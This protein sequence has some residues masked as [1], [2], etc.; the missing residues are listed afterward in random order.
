M[1]DPERPASIESEKAVLGAILLNRDAIAS[2][3][4]TLKPGHFDYERHNQI[5]AAMLTLFQQHIPPD[6]RTVSEELR[7][8]GLLEQVGGVEYLSDLTHGVP[9]SYHIGFYA[10]DML[11]SATRRQLLTAVGKIAALA[12]NEQEDVSVLMEQAHALLDGAGIS[13]YDP[14]YRPFTADELDMEQL[15]E[16]IWVIPGLLPA[17]LTLLIGKPKMRKSW[18]ALATGIAVASG[19][20]ALGAIPVE[21]GDVLYLALE[22]SKNRLQ[23]RQ[24]KILS[25]GSAPHRLSYMTV[26][27]RVD[28]GL[29][30]TVETW[31]RRHTG[32]RLVIIDVLAKVRPKSSGRGGSM[33]DEDYAAIGPLQQLAQRRGIA[34]LVVHHMNR[35]DA[36]DSYDQIN[37]SNGVGGAADG[38]WTLQYDRGQ[39][40]AVLTISSREIEDESALALHWDTTTAQWILMGKAED[41]KVGKERI[42]ILRVMREEKRAMGAKEVADVLGKFGSDYQNLR[43]LMYRMA[44]EGDL[45]PADRGKYIVPEL[46]LLASPGDCNIV[47][48]CDPDPITS[49]QG[50]LLPQIDD[51][52]RCDPIVR[53]SK[54]A[55]IPDHMDHNDTFDASGRGADCDMAQDPIDHNVTI[56]PFARLSAHQ[57]TILRL[58]L[59]SNKESDQERAQEL[60][61]EYGIDYE[62]TRLLVVSEGQHG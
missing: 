58:Y 57:S 24:R 29:I 17:G 59:R 42:E 7:R 53:D 11:K 47:I 49:I 52:D 55:G 16:A 5:Y 12:Y 15:P 30:G 35:S 19:G 23:S 43:Q 26:A 46:T 10:T 36:T 48:P 14:R 60:C 50:T 33:Y 18:L 9:T 56:D 40:D 39:I 34:V 51:C 31:L 3:S 62:A 45:Q 8:R 4:D 28:E 61:A 2:V 32:A 22:D 25:G 37:G 54:N 1:S 21:A 27:P 20:R 44:K 38:L 6:T 13:L 41:I